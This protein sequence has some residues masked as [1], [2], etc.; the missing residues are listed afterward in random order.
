MYLFYFPYCKWFTR[1]YLADDSASPADLVKA[2]HLLAGL[3]G[4]PAAVPA[5]NLELT[6]LYQRLNRCMFSIS[7]LARWI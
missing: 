6:R 2:H 3:T 7:W 5:V 1:C 4:T